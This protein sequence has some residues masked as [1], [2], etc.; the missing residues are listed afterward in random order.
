LNEKPI[1]ESRAILISL[2]ARSMPN[3]AGELPFSS[4]PVEGQLIIRAPKGL[5]LHVRNGAVQASSPYRDGRYRINL[6]RGLGT[7]WLMLK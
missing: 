7:Y 2:G 3:S 6:D 5:R 1:R 4:E